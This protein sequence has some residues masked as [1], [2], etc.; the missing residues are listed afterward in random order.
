MSTF[1]EIKVAEGGFRSDAIVDTFGFQLIVNKR[2]IVF[3]CV[4]NILIV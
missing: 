1:F 4:K 3:L 2:K